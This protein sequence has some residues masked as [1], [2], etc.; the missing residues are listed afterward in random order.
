MAALSRHGERWS[1]EGQ[2]ILI[3]GGSSGIG[4]ACA[5]RL[6]RAGATVVVLARG[7]EALA[8]AR[9]ALG[10]QARAIAADVGDPIAM[11]EAV[12]RAAEQLGG[13][14]AIV[15]GAGVGV[16][17]P[18][19]EMTPDDYER[20]VRTTLL[21]VLN[22]AHAGLEHLERTGGTLVMV[23]SIASRVPMPW[24][25]SYAA[26]KHGVRGFARALHAEL[27]ALG[28][29]VRV[30]LVAPGPVDTPFWHR[31]RTTDRRLPPRIAG[32]YRPEDV[33]RAVE[34][35]L[36]SPR[37]ERTVGGLMSAW[38]FI[39]AVAPNTML[40]LVG[41]LAGLG[42]RNREQRPVNREDSLTKPTT[43]AV[44]EGGLLSRPSLLGVIRD[45]ARA[46]RD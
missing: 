26:A 32:T 4:L 40:R 16:Y 7:E 23:S 29:P 10:P 11:R 45:R 14:D 42:W 46:G 41:L 2:R 27:R 17:G 13:L 38:G 20:S 30:A 9:E 24:L 18:F 5:R 31:T 19:T 6:T 12:Q 33:A 35:A 21:G 3:T 1:P 39:D 44:P 43:S 34:H 28:S 36:H 37:P 8:E 15:A 25:S 22:T